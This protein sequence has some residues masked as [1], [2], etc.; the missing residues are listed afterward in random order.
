MRATMGKTS[1]STAVPIA[2]AMATIFMAA[3][4]P[5]SGPPTEA[6][7]TGVLALLEAVTVI[8]ADIESSFVIVMVLDAVDGVAVVGPV[9]G[10]PAGAVV[11]GAVAVG[12]VFII[13][14]IHFCWV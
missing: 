4:G 10:V 8:V 13:E 12:G 2:G 11:A 7:A 3:P 5:P 9:V 1:E 6:T 14:S